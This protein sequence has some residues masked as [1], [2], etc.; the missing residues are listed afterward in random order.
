MLFG[1]ARCSPAPALYHAMQGT[2][3]AL[4]PD[5][6]VTPSIPFV[7]LYDF[8]I[9]FMPSI[10]NLHLCK[11]LSM[12]RPLVVHSMSSMVTNVLHDSQLVNGLN[13]QNPDF[14][15]IWS[16]YPASLEELT[17]FVN[18][19]NLEHSPVTNG[20]F[21]GLLGNIFLASYGPNPSDICLVFPTLDPGSVRKDPQVEK[22]KL[23]TFFLSLFAIRNLRQLV[24]NKLLSDPLPND[25]LTLRLWL[26]GIR[27][28]FR[29][30][31][32]TTMEKLGVRQELKEI[33]S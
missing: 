19:D 12:V 24:L 20:L 7:N 4:L 21:S 15:S 22:Q 28:E 9:S 25:A 2:L 29:T 27:N 13:T 18:V 32:F 30:T 14:H 17:Q 33:L 11:Y 10:A 8:S 16:F 3:N 1:D 31:C 23:E 26:L 6:N 5:G